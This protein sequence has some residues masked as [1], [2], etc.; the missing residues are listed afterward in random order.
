[1]DRAGQTGFDYPAWDIL[2]DWSLRR[3]NTDMMQLFIIA[4]SP[5]VL[6]SGAQI[7]F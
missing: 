1:M 6:I 7:Q 4:L 2:W 3:D 5:Q